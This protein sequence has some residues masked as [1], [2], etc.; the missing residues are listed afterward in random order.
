MDPLWNFKIW[1]DQ[2]LMAVLVKQNV[3]PEKLLD[4]A[5]VFIEEHELRSEIPRKEEVETAI[6]VRETRDRLAR[7][8][9]ILEN[10]EKER[11]PKVTHKL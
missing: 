9:V 6:A 7:D 2:F 3:N 5:R 8:K 1:F 4:D 11:G 10:E